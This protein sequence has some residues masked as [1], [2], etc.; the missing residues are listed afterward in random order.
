MKRAWL[1]VDLLHQLDASRAYLLIAGDGVDKSR[2]EQRI[3]ERGLAER[4]RLIGWQEDPSELYAAA[5]VTLLPS[6]F[7]GS[8]NAIL[9][10]FAYSTP[11]LGATAPGIEEMLPAEFR[12]SPDNLTPAI[13]TLRRLMKDPEEQIRARTLIEELRKPY[14]FDWNAKATELITTLCP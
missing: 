11:V 6:A 14:T 4:C 13:D 8:P 2:I 7:E 9:E 3:A 12:F 1:T 5:D 10:S